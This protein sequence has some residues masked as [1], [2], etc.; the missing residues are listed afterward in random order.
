[1]FLKIIIIEFLH[2]IIFLLL[3]LWS[4]QLS[5]KG[6]CIQ[7]SPRR[8]NRNATPSTST[9]ISLGSHTQLHEFKCNQCKFD[10]SYML[11]GIGLVDLR[12]RRPWWSR[13]PWQTLGLLVVFSARKGPCGTILFIGWWNPI[14]YTIYH[15]II[16]EF[17]LKI[18]NR[19]KKLLVIITKMRT[20]LLK[21]C[22]PF[23]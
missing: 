11:V 22:L 20:T 18:S 17:E 13:K 2:L 7:W 10:L 16:I 9:N 1:L 21:S 3:L 12:A 8:I 23:W 4:F 5:K 19:M 15:I 14:W 6:S